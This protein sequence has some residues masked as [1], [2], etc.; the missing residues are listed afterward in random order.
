[1]DPAPAKVAASAPLKAQLKLQ[2]EVAQALKTERHN[3]GAL[4]IETIEVNPVM[5]NDKIVDLQKQ[6]EES[7]HRT[8]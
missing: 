4:D 1:M 5:Q 8:D 3:H 7:G 6:R 2:D